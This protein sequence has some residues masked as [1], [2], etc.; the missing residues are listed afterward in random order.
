MIVVA[1]PK[2]RDCVTITISMPRLCVQ[3][4]AFIVKIILCPIISA[5]KFTQKRRYHH[6]NLVY[7]VREVLPKAAKFMKYILKF[8]SN[9]KM[10]YH[11]N[12]CY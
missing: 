3:P 10:A 11:G 4:W 6:V 2:P 12:M 1:D 9:W 8:L 5:V 7:P